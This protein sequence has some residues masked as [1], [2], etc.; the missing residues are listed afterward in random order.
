MNIGNTIRLLRLDRNIS[1]KELAEKIQMPISTLANYEKNLREPKLVTLK[2]ISNFFNLKLSEFLELVDSLNKLNN[3]EQEE[4]TISKSANK[5]EA[6]LNARI[7]MQEKKI[8][9]QESIIKQQK[10]IIK[11][12]EKQLKTIQ[13][14]LGSKLN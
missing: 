12:Q 13:D 5:K 6:K 10:E 4:F 8:D 3:E 1:Q 11:E 2:K 7:L 14:I 9:E